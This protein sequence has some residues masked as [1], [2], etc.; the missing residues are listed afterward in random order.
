MENLLRD[1]DVWIVGSVCLVASFLWRQFWSLFTHKR[2]RDK[3]PGST[4]VHTEMTS[5]LVTSLARVYDPKPLHGQKHSSSGRGEI[6]ASAATSSS[7]T[8]VERQVDALTGQMD[9]LFTLQEAAMSRLDVMIQEKAAQ[10][11]DEKNMEHIMTAMHA[12][13]KIMKE[14]A[15][16]QTRR[17][18]AL[19]RLLSGLQHAVSFI[20]E[21]LKHSPL[22]ELLK[23]P[24]T[25]AGE[26][27]KE[28]DSVE[29]PKVCLK[30]LKS[31][32]K[33]KPPDV[34]DATQADL[35]EV[36]KLNQQNTE[37]SHGNTE[38][39]TRAAELLNLIRDEQEPQAEKERETEKEVLE[40]VEEKE[41]DKDLLA[42]FK[43]DER[44]E[45]QR[46][47][48]KEEEKKKTE[49]TEDSSLPEVLPLPSPASE[50]G[51]ES[52]IYPESSEENVDFTGSTKRR[53]T[54]E[55]VEKDALKKSRVEEASEEVQKSEKEEK[56]EL[57]STEVGPEETEEEKKE[58]E[59]TA[60]EYIIDCSPPPP[61]PFEHRVVTSKTHQIATYYMINREEVLGGGRFGMVHKCVE[62]SSGL[63]L[64]A[65][66]IKARSQ[67]EK[68]VVKSEIEVMNQLNHANLIQLYAAYE[69]RYDITLVMEYVEGGELFDRIID[70]NYKLTEL[71]TVLFI[72][73]ITEGLQYMHKMYILHLDL[74]IGIPVSFLGEDDNEDTE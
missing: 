20:A 7:F 26:R 5:S 11:T 15:E 50:V 23:S 37:L 72:R 45:G 29:K 28:K 12:D 36:Q 62:K 49:K 51:K 6:K 8:M 1:K 14:Q 25:Q 38:T 48:S 18:D 30:G 73:Q 64:A 32:K 2:K 13:M 35:E 53:V 40:A 59:P 24:H 47:V 33:K 60:E 3:S 71:D 68:E 19:E 34:A 55:N 74:K 54:N 17:L 57:D 65:K 69:S 31:Q 67:K 9:K 63:T 52:T 46:D 66:I 41:E 42:E 4:S 70:E 61:A 43:L 27:V 22:S 21:V 10:Q 56:P 39:T 58:G 44:V 16:Q